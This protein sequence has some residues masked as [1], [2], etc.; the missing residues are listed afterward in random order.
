MTPREVVEIVPVEIPGDQRAQ[1]ILLLRRE[2]TAH[3]QE[4]HFVF[5]SF[6]RAGH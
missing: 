6:L 4:Q 5:G 3:A 2:F 1:A